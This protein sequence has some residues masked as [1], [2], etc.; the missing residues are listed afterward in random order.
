MAVPVMKN[1]RGSDPR[2]SIRLLR[3]LLGASLASLCCC[4]DAA[5][6]QPPNVILISAHGLRADRLGCYGYE[7]G[8]TPTLDAF[9]EKATLFTDCASTSSE[10]L[11]ALAS[12]WTG[13]FPNAHGV[14][15]HDSLF[16]TSTIQEL[17]KEKGVSD[18]GHYEFL[19]EECFASLL[20]RV[21]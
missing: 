14:K 7:A 13:L 11:P 19:L 4:V 9:A 15:S 8:A 12:M 3:A 6:S 2:G 21:R 10:T 5:H 18:P 17:L 16:C 20:G 1:L